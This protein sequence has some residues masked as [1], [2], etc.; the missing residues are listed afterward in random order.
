MRSQSV[1]VK[2][3][4]LGLFRV[5]RHNGEDDKKHDSNNEKIRKKL[6]RGTIIMVAE[7]LIGT[8]W[9]EQLD[10]FFKE[11]RYSSPE[12][13]IRSFRINPIPVEWFEMKLS[14]AS[15]FSVDNDLKEGSERI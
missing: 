1:G 2:Q 6:R 12:V 7:Y 3:I 9:N 14:L 13:F 11:V 8:I 4:G 15:E 10:G 5:S